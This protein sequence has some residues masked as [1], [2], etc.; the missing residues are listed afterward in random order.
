[1][2]GHQRDRVKALREA[3]RALLDHAAL[4]A[5]EAWAPGPHH[6]MLWYG[7]P[8]KRESLRFE[9]L[10]PQPARAWLAALVGDLLGQAHAYLMPC[11]A[12]LQL[13]SRFDRVTGLELVAAIERVREEWGGG[14][15]VYGPVPR[16]LEQPSPAPAAALAMAQRRFGLF[17]E[18]ADLT[19]W[20]GKGRPKKKSPGRKR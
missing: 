11:E 19:A 18:L 6:A 4:S 2:A 16:P 1:L 13:A 10:A 8:D 5:S 7:E 9:P 12:V 17:F 15:S 14:Q 20:G 3:L